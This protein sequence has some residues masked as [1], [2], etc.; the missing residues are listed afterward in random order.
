VTGW[1]AFLLGS[2]QGLTEF[3]PISSSGHLALMEKAMK[4]PSSDSMKTFDVFVHTATLVAI[5]IAFRG[6][7]VKLFTVRR[8]WIAKLI[9]ASIPT[10]ALV[11]G[12]K[13]LLHIDMQELRDLLRIGL[14]YIAAGTFIAW[15]AWYRKNERADPK[16]L[17]EGA[18]T[19]WGAMW[20]GAAQMITPMGAWSRSGMTISA[21]R[22]AKIESGTAI[23]FS[24]LLGAIAIGGATILDYK[25]IG[26]ILRGGTEIPQMSMLIGF[27]SALAFG[28]AAIWLLRKVVVRGWFLYFG[29]YDVLL[30]VTALVWWWLTPR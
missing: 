18:V 30:G 27:C 28:W 6:E 5:L 21:G 2:T 8:D 4:L 11:F 17:P 15:A 29:M 3:L 23:S 7:I 19:W 22:L 16:T 13:K 20:V 24:F 25:E 14:T 10:A 1:E 9:V 26:T 12:L